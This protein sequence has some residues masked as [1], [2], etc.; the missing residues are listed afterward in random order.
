MGLGRLTFLR[1]ATEQ[2]DDSWYKAGRECDECGDEFSFNDEIFVLEVKEATVENGELFMELIQGDDGKPAYVTQVLH[3]ECW[4][5]AIEFMRDAM[6]DTPPVT[7]EEPIMTCSC[8]ESEIGKFEP[9]VASTFG[10]IQCSKR[11]PNNQ[12]TTTIERL[13]QMKPVCLLCIAH[14]LEDH[15][16]GWEEL[17][18]L[19]P[20]VEDAD[21]DDNEEDEGVD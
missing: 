9:F 6:A 18:E 14:V 7:A 19:T 12:S 3:L 13:G 11:A 4:E 21:E 20:D 8:C 15:F 10:E 16:A 2:D 5:D 1:A 17:A